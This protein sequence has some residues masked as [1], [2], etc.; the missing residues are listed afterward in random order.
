[1]FFYKALDY[2][3]HVTFTVD[4]SPAMK[5]RRASKVTALVRSRGTCIPLTPNG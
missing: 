4:N 1:M 2:P 5:L 3:D